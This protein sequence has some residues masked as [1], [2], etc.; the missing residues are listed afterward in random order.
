MRPTT[1]KLIRMLILKLKELN[2]EKSPKTIASSSA[3]SMSIETELKKIERLIEFLDTNLE[4]RKY[5][6]E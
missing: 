4:G 3:R 5:F 6:G 1:S 2:P